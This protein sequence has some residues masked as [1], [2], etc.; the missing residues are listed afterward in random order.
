VP[1]DRLF[2]PG[3]TDGLGFPRPPLLLLWLIGLVIMSLATAVC[4]AL[5]LT[6]STVGFVYLAVIAL[7]SL[8]DSLASSLV[9]SVIAVALL[10]YFFIEPIFSFQID[11]DADF[12][13]LIAFVVTSF[14]ITGLVRR[15]RTLG[16]A[17]REQARLLDLTHDAI[18]VRGLD[19]VISFWNRGAEIAYGW[20]SGEA[21]GQTSHE[22]LQTVYPEGLD[23][24]MDAV[25]NTGRWE[26]ELSRIR[27]DG[28]G[29][30]V[31]SRWSLEKDQNGKPIGLLEINTDITER[32]RA[33]EALERVQAAYLAEA[34][35]L[36]HTGSFAWLPEAREIVW[37]EESA[38]IYGYGFTP[39]PDLESLMKPVHPDDR[40]R[41]QEVF[42]RAGAGGEN[43]DFEYRL[44]QADGMQRIVHVVAHVVSENGHGRQFVGAIMD[45]TEA[46]RAQEQLQQAQANLAHVARVTTL[47]QLTAS[48]GHEVNQPLAA[49]VTNGEAAIR[50]LRRDPP[51]LDE[52][53]AALTSM[54][55]EGKRASEIVRRIR[56]MVQ[57]TT[58]LTAPIDINDLLSECTALVQREIAAN[59]VV[60][61]LEFTPDLPKVLGD[62]VQLQQVVINLMINAIQAMADVEGRMRKLIVRSRLGEAGMVAVAVVDS[63]PG[64][65]AE[66]AA[67]L[68]DAF[69]S[70]KT[71][72]MG[73]GLSICRTII[74]THTGRI[75]AT[76]IEGQSATFSFTLPAAA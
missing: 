49:I 75:S 63:G 76:A 57:K 26:G 24:V 19:H 71:D 39:R 40:A 12:S 33:Q 67:H 10:D 37:S 30:V 25:L 8:M 38:R 65:S 5:G 73:M 69:Y 53:R 17:Q 42:Q 62:A 14:A 55:A 9:F 31:A 46:R 7:L 51:E 28:V 48:I 21:V 68:F 60:L 72:G 47:G 27:K 16:E 45:I 29:I 52:V 6:T 15:V 50:Y 58:P 32:K 20:K 4:F 3:L 23:Q 44:V 70:T 64:F 13:T 35:S 11:F 34:Q 61:Q 43:I 2:R 36:S 22:L 54:I 74:E 1:F 41:V 66:K 56:S 18:F 59:Q